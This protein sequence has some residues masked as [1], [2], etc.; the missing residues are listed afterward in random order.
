MQKRSLGPPTSSLARLVL[1]L[2]ALG[3]LPSIATGQTAKL[4]CPYF[5][6]NL[7]Q[8]TDCLEAIFSEDDR[9]LYYTHLTV[10]SVPPGNGFSLGIVTAD[11]TH[12]VS[13]FAPRTLPDMRKTNPNIFAVRSDAAFP[14]QPNSGGRK[15]LFVPRVSVAASTNGSWYA[16]GGFDWLPPLYIN[17]P[18]SGPVSNCNK[19][20]KLCTDTVLTLHLEGTHSVARTISFYG[21]GPPSPN[22]QYTFRLDQTYGGLQ[23]RLPL[24]DYH[25]VNTSG[26]F[27]V[28]SG[29]EAHYL[30]LPV[31]ALPASVY[32]HFTDATL[33]GL[34]A[35]P[36]YIHSNVGFIDH[37]T[38]ISEAQ[39]KAGQLLKR[40]DAVALVSSFT[41]HWYSDTS[42]SASSF[43][44]A[45][46]NIDLSLEVGGIFQK[47]VTSSATHLRAFFPHAF[48]SFVQDRCAGPPA[49]PPVQLP[50]NPTKEDIKKAR[51]A[52]ADY[53]KDNFYTIQITHG[54]RCDFGD[55]TLTAHLAASHA[56]VGD[57]IPFFM[58]PTVGGQDIDSLTSLRG[59]ADYRFRGTDATFVQASY[60]LPVYDPLGLLVFYD[61]GNAGDTLG[62]LSFAHLRQD[63]GVG[64]NIRIMRV[65][66][67]QAYVAWGAGSG[68]YLGY[69]LVKQF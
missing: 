54:D 1:V 24:A 31:E 39:S 10:G 61:A 20:G 50:P 5:F 67:A 30:Q 48:Y 37:L 17:S 4:S 63:A 19:L 36:T 28:A 13:A 33:P 29:I 66:Y 65:S 64:V 18:R 16:T 44:Q 60:M 55:I 2:A 57:T 42:S 59:F 56:P 53:I 41:Y 58:R 69:N 21:L 62:A 22:T 47:D 12:F 15:S 51:K 40:R 11:P 46:A 9:S 35:Q 27:S 68:A 7:H 38:H 52:A 26:E 45:V 14:D 25:T 6:D 23:G 8:A 3:L 34:T 43:Q 32:T 49:K